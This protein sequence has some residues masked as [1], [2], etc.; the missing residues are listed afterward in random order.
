MP[1]TDSKKIDELMSRGVVE[2]SDAAN[3][4]QKLLSGKRLRVKL[5]IDPTGPALHLGRSIPLLKLRDFQQLGHQI[6]LILGTFTGQIG[7][8]SDKDSERPMLT[9]SE[10]EQNM[11]G[12]LDQIGMVL[13]MSQVEV[14]HNG[15][16]L[17]DLKL[18]DLIKLADAFSLHEFT[19]RELIKRRL[20][21]G[22]RVN[23]REVLYPLMQ[24]YDSVAVES[25]VEIGGTDQWF[26]MLTGRRLQPLYG[27]VGQ[28]VMTLPII[29]GTDGAKMS[30]S[31]GNTVLL[32]AAPS[33]MYGAI[34]SAQDDLIIP[35]FEL[36]TRV[37]LVE[38]E[39]AKQAL[40]AG[41]NPRDIKMK[42]AR[43]ITAFYHGE[44]ASRQAEAD[45]VSVFQQNSRPDEI[46]LVAVKGG[47]RPLASLLTEVKLAASK[48]EARRLIE[49]GGVRVDDAVITDAAA[50]ISVHDG[51]VLQ[52]GKRRWAQLSVNE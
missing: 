23:L 45:F 5:G 38:V 29:N 33:E 43:E 9:V 48:G 21:E 24:G 17:N 15:D 37:A 20:D 30:T 14:R 42:L 28:E 22:K 16:W 1:D 49:Q 39:A 31:R 25:D 7:D 47:E 40:E 4:R 3:L 27:Q 46:P 13:D 32:Q 6:V 19:A 11:S 34:M 35:Y 10:I 36:L 18:A 50:Q 12:Y 41:D 44:S 51:M 26:N 2:I 8:T 52:V